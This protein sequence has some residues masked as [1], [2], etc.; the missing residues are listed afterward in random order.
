MCIDFIADVN[1]QNKKYVF[2]IDKI[3]KNIYFWIIL[4]SHYKIYEDYT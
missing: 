4:Q 2:C 1:I 3:H